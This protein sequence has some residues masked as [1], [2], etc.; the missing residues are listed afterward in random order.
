MRFILF[1]SALYIGFLSNALALESSDSLRL[2][3]LK[4]YNKNIL[5]L[6]RGLEDGII[7]KDHIK[8]TSEDGFIAR[9]ICLKATL[10]TSHWKIYRVVRPQLVSKDSI[11]TAYSINQSEIPSDIAALR[12]VDFTPYLKDY[13]DEDVLK[14]L[15]MQQER[16]AKYDLPTSVKE[17]KNFQYNSKSGVQ[18]LIDNTFQDRKIRRDLSKNY[19]NIFASPYSVQTRFDQKEVHYGAKLYNKG[20][21]YRYEL[22]AL[23][24][25]RRIIDPVTQEGYNSKTTHYDFSFQINRA[26]QNLS[27]ITYLSYDRQKIG[28]VYYPHD[29]YQVGIFGLK[30]HLWEEDPKNNFAD[31]SYIPVFDSLE[32][33]NP[34]SQDGTGL[35][36]LVGVRHRL[37]LNFYN[38]MSDKLHN[39][40]SIIYS[41]FMDIASLELENDFV[42]FNFSTMFSYNLGS[43][44]F[45]DYGVDYEQ[46]QFRGDTYNIPPTN[47]TQT[48]RFRYEFML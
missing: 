43:K 12:P 32:Y 29:R 28:E 44:F 37:S 3:I 30:L 39:K 31:L 42:N 36:E 24:A 16:I 17:T 18:K 34:N 5:V 33:S 14:G 47:L 41:P 21:K 22:N 46:D 4:S 9:G 35:T 11:Y 19:L 13:S 45:A 25:Q 38:D 15:E 27:I 10:L 6:S 23:E 40:T 2:K 26:T 7:V 20:E 48:V 8:I 1:F